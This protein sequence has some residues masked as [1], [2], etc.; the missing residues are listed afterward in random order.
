MSRPNPKLYSA[1]LNLGYICPSAPKI[2]VSLMFFHKEV[3]VTSKT[4]QSLDHMKPKLLKSCPELEHVQV[5][6]RAC[7]KNI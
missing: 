4:M 3:P 6:L 5:A 2:P 1:L 7:L